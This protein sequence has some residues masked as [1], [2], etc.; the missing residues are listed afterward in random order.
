MKV[1][2]LC[3]SPLVSNLIH[4]YRKMNRGLHDIPL[5]LIFDAGKESGSTGLL[6]F[7][8]AQFPVPFS[9]TGYPLNLFLFTTWYCVVVTEE[10]SSYEKVTSDQVIGVLL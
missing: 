4:N 5:F 10:V 3:N 6:A 1:L 9:A 7:V 2:S 8:Y